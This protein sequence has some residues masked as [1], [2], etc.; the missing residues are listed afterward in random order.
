[1]QLAKRGKRK[2]YD[3]VVRILAACENALAFLCHTD[4]RKQLP[5]YFALFPERISVPE[6]F[7]GRVGSEH[8]HRRAVLV[9]HLIEPAP[10]G[11]VDVEHI[12]YCRG[13]AFKNYALCLAVAVLHLVSSGTELGFEVAD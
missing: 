10:S 13:I 5:F 9:I 11:H 8:D 2:A 7:L 4:D 3:V 1:M 12:F 6:K